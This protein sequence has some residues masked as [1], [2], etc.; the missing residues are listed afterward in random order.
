MIKSLLN[1]IY[2]KKCMGCGEIITEENYF[3]DFCNKN[4][5]KNNLED[6]CI[7]CGQEKSECVC[8]LNIYRFNGLV[9]VYKNSGAFKKAYY[10]YKFS[11][12][13]HYVKVFAQELSEAINQKYSDINFD[14]LCAVP[15]SKGFVF[16]NSYDHCGYICRELS[17]SL[18]IPIAKNLLYCKRGKKKQHKL[19]IKERLANV[20][21]KFNYNYRID[22]ATILLIDDIKTTGATL[23]ECA[24]M[25]LYAGAERVFCATLIT[26]VVKTKK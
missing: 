25:L 26:S 7:A 22:G 14:F 21:N 6:W 23:D 3:C 16:Q 15:K 12:K 9:S 1:A 10:S 5:E 11:Q 8:K 2:P 18:K 24:K 20:D 13:Q 17:K 4:L 19:T